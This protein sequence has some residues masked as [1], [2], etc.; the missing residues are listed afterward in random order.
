MLL[1][2]YIMFKTAY[3][4]LY[5]NLRIGVYSGAGSYVLAYIPDFLT[6]ENLLKAVAGLGAYAGCFV[7]LASV[8]IAAIKM[9][10]E[11]KKVKIKFFKRKRLPKKQ[12]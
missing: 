1:N 5:D 4:Y 7:A 9:V 10:N 12:L 11:V 2:Q 8:P 3:C 6:N